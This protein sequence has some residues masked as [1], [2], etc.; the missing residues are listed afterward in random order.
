MRSVSSIVFL[1]AYINILATSTHQLHASLTQ[2]VSHFFLN[3]K[4]NSYVIHKSEFMS[5]HKKIPPTP[6]EIKIFLCVTFNQGLVSKLQEKNRMY[7]KLA[8]NAEEMATANL[9][10]LRRAQVSRT[11]VWS[12]D[13]IYIH[14]GH[15]LLSSLCSRLKQ[16]P[17][18]SRNF[19]RVK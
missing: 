10:R 11:G 5:I 15:Y 7:K 14:Y 8:E 19:P 16:R 17:R 2:Y 12:P 13:I 4:S 6:N 9:A 1:V 3:Y 18:K